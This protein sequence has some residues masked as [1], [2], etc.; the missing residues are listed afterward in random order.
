MFGRKT[1]KIKELEKELK[2]WEYTGHFSYLTMLTRTQL[3]SKI[4][5]LQSEFDIKS[6]EIRALK[7]DLLAAS[8]K[9]LETI[10]NQRPENE[11]IKPKLTP[12]KPIKK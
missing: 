11:P 10:H 2:K 4:E 1:K 3:I 12:K 5:E 7:K 6:D 8:Q 9:L